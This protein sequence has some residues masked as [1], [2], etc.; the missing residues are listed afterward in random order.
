MSEKSNAPAAK[1]SSLSLSGAEQLR[2]S[3]HLIFFSGILVFFFND[4]QHNQKTKGTNTDQQ[5]KTKTMIVTNQNNRHNVI[6]CD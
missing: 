2:G 4:H 6:S 1:S 3:D 5:E